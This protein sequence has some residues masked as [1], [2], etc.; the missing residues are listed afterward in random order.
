MRKGKLPHIVAVSA[1]LLCVGGRLESIALGTGEIDCTY[2]FSAC[3]NWWEAMKKASADKDIKWL[4][5][6]LK[7]AA[8]GISPT[9]R[10]I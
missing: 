5:Q 6:M 3:R 1:E 7:G 8:F 2:H 10:S 9:Y 4:Q